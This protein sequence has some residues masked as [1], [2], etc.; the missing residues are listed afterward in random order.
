MRMSIKCLYT[1]TKSGF[2]VISDEPLL[3]N[4]GIGINVF[5][6]AFQNFGLVK[7]VHVD[8]NIT[9]GPF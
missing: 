5:S 9:L 6:L 4:T 3:G 1:F 7:R 8:E 2:Y